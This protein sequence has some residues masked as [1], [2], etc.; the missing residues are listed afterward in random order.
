MNAK[1]LSADVI[2]YANQCGFPITNLKLQ[3]TLYYLQ[4][5]YARKYG[6]ELFPEEMEHWPYGPVIPTVYF[7]YCPFGANAISIPLSDEP[8]FGCGTE[9]KKVL[10]TVIDKCLSMTARTLVEKTHTELPWKNTQA[11]EII[12]FNAIL[13]FFK[14][15]NPL[16][17]SI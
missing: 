13:H 16:D 10:T 11:S 3:K 4:G 17:I 12:P 1:Q 8:F 6:E 5:Y 15:N 14:E 9:E 7:E 2:T